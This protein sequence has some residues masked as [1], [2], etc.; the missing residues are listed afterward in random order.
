MSWEFAT[1]SLAENVPGYEILSATGEGAM[2]RVYVARQLALGR[3]VA[4]KFLATDHDADP[5]ARVAR[6]RREAAIMAALT[7]P[8]VLPVFDFGEDD[9]RFFLAMEYVEGGDLRKRMPE[10][11]GMST[12][13]TLAILVPVGEALDYL[14]ARG[15]LHRD[16]KPENILMHGDVPKVADFGIAVER[17]GS[18]ELTR[19]SQGLGTLGYVAPELQYRLPVDERA[20]Q[21][22]LAAMAYEMLTGVRPLGLFKAPSHYNPSLS[23]NVD[24]VLLRG[25]EESPGDRF[26]TVLAFVRAL[27]EAC[28]VE[29]P[30]SAK[31]R[32]K[33]A[34]TLVGLSFMT[35]AWMVGSP[36]VGLIQPFVPQ[37]RSPVWPKKPSPRMKALIG[38]KSREIWRSQGEPSGREGAAV[39]KP[40]WLTAER[41]VKQEISTR[42]DHVWKEGVWSRRYTKDTDFA[43][44]WAKAE[45]QLYEEW[46]VDPSKLVDLEVEET[47]IEQEDSP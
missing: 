21:Y 42:A 1:R 33:I 16:L 19:S 3:L 44:V 2:G 31:W 13:A 15:I 26:P 36:L 30:V 8:N 43:E 41:L 18:G 37:N 32:P 22:S 6:F 24:R 25:L 11:K 27:G 9:G 17:E 47:P 5:D 40:N 23:P 39:E 34:L 29:R 46:R 28:G 45:E 14:H 7:H 35:A 20:D 10:G 4:L 12:Q 38:W